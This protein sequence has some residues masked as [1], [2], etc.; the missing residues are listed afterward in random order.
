MVNI[1]NHL[2]LNPHVE[3]QLWMTW[4][5]IFLCYRHVDSTSM[6][7]RKVV[8]KLKHQHSQ[9]K[10]IISEKQQGGHVSYSVLSKLIASVKEDVIH[11][12]TVLNIEKDPVCSRLLR[13]NLTFLCNHNAFLGFVSTNINI[14]FIVAVEESLEKVYAIG[15]S[16]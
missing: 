6:Q 13:Y 9:L 7:K 12:S 10:Q 16:L 14:V 4:N 5:S 15:M 11:T 8:T 3:F 1:V 2:K